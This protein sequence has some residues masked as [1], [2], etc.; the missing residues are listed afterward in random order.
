M[1]TPHKC[2]ECQGTGCDPKPLEAPDVSNFLF[3]RC[4][5]CKGK[6]A[7]SEEQ[8]QAYRKRQQAT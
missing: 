4:E 2:P 5:L 1:Q 7:L 8:H 3:P 6:G